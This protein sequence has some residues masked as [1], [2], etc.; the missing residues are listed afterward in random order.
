MLTRVMRPGVGATTT[1][2]Y[3]C[4]EVLL[5]YPISH[6]E[7]CSPIKVASAYTMNFSFSI[8]YSLVPL[9]VSL[10]EESDAHIGCPMVAILDFHLLMK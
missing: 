3:N 7:H 9:G 6:L 5:G 2:F 4:C 10:L 1:S 8:F